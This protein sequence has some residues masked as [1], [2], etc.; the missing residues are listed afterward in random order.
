MATLA[1]E[2]N[3]GVD[4]IS[5]YQEG[6]TYHQVKDLLNGIVKDE[7]VM[8]RP[9]HNAGRQPSSFQQPQPVQLT[10]PQVDYT[11]I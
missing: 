10:S 7:Q 9:V 11:G 2:N 8:Q 1:E 4:V 6:E 3:G 5:A